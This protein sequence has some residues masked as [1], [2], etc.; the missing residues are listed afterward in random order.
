MIEREIG[1]F[2]DREID[3]SLENDL[4]RGVLQSLKDYTL[5]G[6]K[7]VRG[8]L[9]LMG[10]RSVGG[11]DISRARLASVG[12]ELIQS[13]LIIHD[14]I[15][16]RSDERRGRDSFHIEYSK[17]GREMDILGD[18][19]R[20]G[21]NMAVISGDLAEAYG[22]K[23]IL[24]TGFPPERVHKALKAQADMIRDT[25]F[26]QIL[27]IYSGQLEKWGEEDVLKVH[28]YKTAKYTFEGPLHIG[29]HLNGAT[30]KQL[31]ALSDFAI[32]AGIAFQLIDDILGFF[33]DP[34]R[35]GEEDL[36]DI[37][38]GK[39]TL[40]VVK[41]MEL[42]GGPESDFIRE[43]VGNE[44]I[45]VDEANR[46]RRIIRSCGSEDYSRKLAGSYSKRALEAL[47]PDLLDRD[48]IE[49]LEGFTDYLMNR[50]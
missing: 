16:D 44:G 18:P 4:T 8:T 41:A 3:L 11:T 26:G 45:S 13:M 6:G 7:R 21:E 23:A 27:D 38:E 9:V 20:F 50:A 48:V 19:D 39:M 30:E 36:A 42:V 17:K 31:K 24:E 15:I 46:L 33:G 37:K 32:P 14:D 12:L 10:Y 43:M 28:E 5:N 2:L 34:K 22:E 40:L 25:G 49:F 47:D 35:G 1:S 29:A